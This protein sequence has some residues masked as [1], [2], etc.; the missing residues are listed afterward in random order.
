VI[1]Q[2]ATVSGTWTAGVTS[3]DFT[4]GTGTATADETV[5][6]GDIEYSPGSVI[7]QVNPSTIYTPGTDARLDNTT[8]LTAMSTSDESGSGGVSW[9]PT[10]TVHLPAQTVAGTYSGIITHSVG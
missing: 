1:D 10:I 6:A 4:T 7:T 9:N 3:T 2:R 8:S 5:A